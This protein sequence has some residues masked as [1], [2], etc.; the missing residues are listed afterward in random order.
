MDSIARNMDKAVR[1]IDTA[2]EKSPETTRGPTPHKEFPKHDDQKETPRD[3][4][5]QNDAEKANVSSNDVTEKPKINSAR[6]IN[7]Y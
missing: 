6:Y 7:G 4:P 1:K 3:A 2:R 5:S